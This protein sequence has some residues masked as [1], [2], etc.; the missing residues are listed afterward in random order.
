MLLDALQLSTAHTVLH[1]SL[2]TGYC[3]LL[4]YREVLVLR[5][6]AKEPWQLLSLVRILP[7]GPGSDLGPA[8]EQEYMMHVGRPRNPQH[9]G[10]DGDGAGQGAPQQGVPPPPPAGDPPGDG[11]G[12]NAMGADEALCVLRHQP[13][14]PVQP[15]SQH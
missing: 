13:V 15:P 8:P 7:R 6:L 5:K 9:Q 2:Q 11:G 10:D 14:R 12:D 1:H 3:R 4:E